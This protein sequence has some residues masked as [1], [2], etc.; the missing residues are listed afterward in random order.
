M[1][2]ISFWWLMCGAEEW[3]TSR[4]RAEYLGEALLMVW[5]MDGKW[6]GE[7]V[8][9]GGER[10]ES[11]QDSRVCFHIPF[12]ASLHTSLFPLGLLSLV[13]FAGSFLVSFRAVIAC[14]HRLGEGDDRS[15]VKA[16]CD[17]NAQVAY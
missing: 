11:G 16:L 2:T 14:L 1:G 9:N 6:C 12:L 17:R 7:W 5:R 4:E 8:E 15:E 13:S 3:K 10:M